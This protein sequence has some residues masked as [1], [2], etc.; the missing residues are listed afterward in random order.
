MRTIDE[1]TGLEVLTENECLLLMTR[2]TVGRLA[3]V[4]GDR[5]AVFPVNF[6]RDGGT[7]V[8]RTDE[9]TKLDLVSGGHPVTFEVDSFDP[10]SHTGWSVVMTGRAHEVTDPDELAALDKLPLRPWTPGP[11]S[12]YVRVVPEQVQGR[13]IV[14]LED[15]HYR[16]EA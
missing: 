16:R 3:V 10:H 14:H 4:D 2:T 5:A 13:R 1:R 15:A 12:R 9:G 7:V 6:R 8:F 11:K